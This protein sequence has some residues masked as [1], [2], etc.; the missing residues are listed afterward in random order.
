M[1]TDY[2]RLKNVLDYLKLNP[3]SLAKA[4]GIRKPDVFYHIKSG[5]NGISDK[6]AKSI[7]DTFNEISF[8]YLSEGKGP[9]L[10]KQNTNKSDRI[11]YVFELSKLSSK[12]FCNIIKY[13]NVDLFI[14]IIKENVSPPKDLIDKILDEFPEISSTWLLSGVG[15]FKSDNSIDKIEEYKELYQAY[16]KN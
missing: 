4:I 16:K 6:L 13:D 1:E 14:R 10:I 15:D 7:S 5:R 3:N 2:Q 11:K 9:M 12:E 8:S